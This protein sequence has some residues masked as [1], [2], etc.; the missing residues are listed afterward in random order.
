MSLNPSPSS[1]PVISLARMKNLKPRRLM[2]ASWMG[3]TS[4][5]S[6]VAKRPSPGFEIAWYRLAAEHELSISVA[7]SG[8]QQ[9]TASRTTVSEVRA[10]RPRHPPAGTRPTATG[11]LRLPGRDRA[12]AFVGQV[13]AHGRLRSSPDELQSEPP[14]PQPTSKTVAAA[15]PSFPIGSAMVVAVSL[16]HSSESL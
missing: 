15:V 6:L 3:S 5:R 8:Q 10:R 16:S 9:R 11:L 7:T 2:F 4:R 12:E 13:D 14:N 1:L